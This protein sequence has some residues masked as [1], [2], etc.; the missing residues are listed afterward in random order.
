MSCDCGKDCKVP[1]GP[2]GPQGPQG[3]QGEVGPQGPSGATG[4]QGEQGAD[5]DLIP[6]VWTDLP[7]KNDWQ[8]AGLQTPQYS[9]KNGILYLRGQLRP[10]AT[11][12]SGAFTDLTLTGHTVNISSSIMQ[13][14][15]PTV[16]SPFT[17]NG[18]SNELIITDY[19]AGAG[20]WSLDSVPP[21]HIR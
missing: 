9:F 5:G 3:D 7:L 6:L 12:A 2:I 1:V 16:S 14:T 21:I 19:S 20:N 13:N 15:L 17:A 4:P 10:G 11:T 8:E 18:F